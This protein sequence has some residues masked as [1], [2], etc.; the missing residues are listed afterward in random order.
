MARN[1]V[2]S[3]GLCLLMALL[4]LGYMFPVAAS[5]S[6]VIPPQQTLLVGVTINGRTQD[7][8]QELVER[9]SELF[10]TR[11][12]LLELGLVAP[13]QTTVPADGLIGL[14]SFEGWSWRLDASTQV[15]ELKV[16]I[17]N[18]HVQQLIARPASS[19]GNVDL[20]D[21]GAVLNYDAQ[22]THDGD[23]TSSSIVNE[24]RIF[25]PLG[26]LQS[27]VQQTRS[28][29]FNRT[30]RLDTTYSV[31]DASTLQS[32]N[33]GDFINA[34]LSWTRPVRMLGVQMTTNFALRPDLVTY[35]RPGIT[36]EV[37]V[38]SSVDI[39]VN[40]LHQTTTQVQPGPFELNQLPVT[41]GGGDVSLV[42]KDASGRQTT[43]TL[44][45]Y[46]STLLLSEGLDSLALQTGLVRR[47]YAT[48]SN[49]YAK[50]AA[51]VSYRH[52]QTP[53]LSLET[54]FET[55]S[56]LAMGGVGANLLVGKLGVL[57]ASAATSAYDG[58][59]GFQYGLGIARNTPYLSFGFSVLQADKRFSDIASANGDSTPG[60]TLRA[61]LGFPILD[62]G[63]LGL[64]YAKKRV[65]LYTVDDY[66]DDYVT[67]TQRTSTSTLSATFSAPL[68][69]KA[70]GF[71]TAY[72]DF[73][74]NSG[75]GL[76]VGISIPIGRAASLSASS[77]RSGSNTYQTVE[78]RNS[79]IQRGDVGWN[80]SRQTGTQTRDDAGVTYKSSWGEVGAAVERN[81]S[82]MAYRATARGALSTVGGR[83]FA[84]NTVY[85]SFAVVD[86][87]G[88]PGITV[89]QENR[90]LGKTDA[91]GLLF[92]EG[93]RA[94]E[95]NNLSID[96]GDVPMDVSLSNAIIEVRP[97]DRSGVIAKFPIRHSRSATLI[98]VDEQYR[99][100]LLGSQAVLSGS[101]EEGIVGYDGVTF[102]NNL[103]EHEQVSV[104]RS[105]QAPCSVS[106]DY[107]PQANAIP[108]IGPL[109]CRSG[110]RP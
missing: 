10:V 70:Y 53:T 19:A 100:L 62:V 28:Q 42:V 71:V 8:I 59:T 98:L 61:N 12:Q 46:A 60:T 40:G 22:F 92:I 110:A 45:F 79:A 77:S 39:Y 101:G 102:F 14:S 41:S 90:P 86:T 32:Y 38:P 55:T 64:V 103:G 52:G 107:Q 33:A 17:R 5:P 50:P 15:L 58:E 91:D 82:D 81:D 105:G 67:S 56:A 16:P 93:L 95:S 18:L 68:P 85:D 74:G 99:P 69:M 57:S 49:D 48:R 104:N 47:E 36:G 29:S 13:E 84:S 26:V 109:I 65:N 7:G 63:T 54:H 43:Q 87:D 78:A 23:Y 73:K 97:S 96:A 66:R 76:F 75:N 88:L 2:L 89:L 44:P 27:S 4:L 6:P 30:V 20:S 1:Q 24:L 72:H 34:G 37:A 83:V 9:G 11:A 94:Y 80:V 3:G 25:G 51:S 106:F 108:Q 21:T 31:S 35:P